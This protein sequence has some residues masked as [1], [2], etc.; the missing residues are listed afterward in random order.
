MPL[1]QYA[2]DGAALETGVPWWRESLWI[3]PMDV[4]ADSLGGEGV[5]RGLIW[6]VR[7][8]I[9]LLALPA[10]PDQMSKVMQCLALGKGAVDG[11]IV[12]VRSR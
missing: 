11:C 8:L 5:S 1:D 7:E 3:V 6:M 2:R 12:D 10:L 4:D 9:A